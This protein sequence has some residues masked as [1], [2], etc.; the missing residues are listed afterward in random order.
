MRTTRKLPLLAILALAATAP[1]ALAEHEPELHNQTPRVTAA[2]EV[3]AAADPACPAV[4]PTPPAAVSPTVTGGGCRLHL[5]SV[6]AVSLTA[7]LSAGGTEALISDCTVEFDL[8]LDAAAEGWL[9][10]AEFTGAPGVCTKRSCGAAAGSEGRAYNFHIQEVEPPARTE[11]A[12]VLF[13]TE[14]LDGTQPSHCEFPFPMTQPSMH[15]YRF[16]AT[17]AP[18]HG[19]V[20]PHCELSGTFDTEAGGGTSGEAQLYQNV[21]IRHT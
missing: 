12:I 9:A 21:E 8:R 4:V 18:G 17:D 13:C 15:R 11:Q 5:A 14:N 10:H 3:H 16:T 6:G 20:F 1:S 7:H 19:G 2:Q